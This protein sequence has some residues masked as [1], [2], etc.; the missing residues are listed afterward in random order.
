MSR[1]AARKEVEDLVRRAVRGFQD[2]TRSWADLE[3]VR[4]A[5][6]DRLEEALGPGPTSRT[7]PA[8][9]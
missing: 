1:V 3:A 5:L 4:G 7:A 6:I 2:Y 9:R 8:P